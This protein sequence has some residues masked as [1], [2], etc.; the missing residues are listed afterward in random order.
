MARLDR[1]TKTSREPAT[2]VRRRKTSNDALKKV[3]MLNIVLTTTL[4]L[5]MYDKYVELYS[6]LLSVLGY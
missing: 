1:K 3:M 2:K 5:I 4:H 6:K